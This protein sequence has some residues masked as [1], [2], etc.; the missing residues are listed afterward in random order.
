MSKMHFECE[1]VVR[2]AG[3]GAKTVAEQ[4]ALR[5]W[6]EPWQ[7]VKDYAKRQG[8]RPS[9]ALGMS[10]NALLSALWFA[11]VQGRADQDAVHHSL[12]CPKP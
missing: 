5:F 9:P 11:Y 8:F 10:R 4:L 2:E 12:S 6:C 7:A 3:V 1:G